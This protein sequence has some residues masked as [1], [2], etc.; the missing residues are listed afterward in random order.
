MAGLFDTLG[1]ATSGLRTVQSGI[2]TTGHNIANADTPGYTRQRSVVEASLPQMT[3]AGAIGTGVEQI[4][5]ERILDRFVGERLVRETSRQA[6]LDTQAAIYRQLESVVTSQEGEGLAGDLTSFFDALDDLSNAISPGQEAERTQLL[7]AGQSLVDSIHRY[8]TQLRDLQRGADR[9]ISG[10][11][12]E[13]NA[14]SAEIASLNQKIAAAEVTSPA[15]DLR[16]QREQLVL[17]LAEKVDIALVTDNQGMLSVR[18]SGGLPLVDKDIAA[19]LDAVVDPANPN[20]FDPSFS[21]VFYTGAG[22]SFDAT[23]L[24]RGGELGGLIEAR[25]TIIGGAIR[26]L[27]AFAYTVAESFNAVHR[28][29][30][31]IV[32]G[33]A[34]D[35]FAD[36]S[37]QASVDDAARNFALSADVD[38]AQGGSL[39]NIAAG[40]VANPVTGGPE[41]ALGDTAWVEQLKD[42]RTGNVANYLAGDVPGTPTGT[43]TTM[44]NALG[45]FIGDIGQGARS[46]ERSLAQQDSVLAAVRNR[47]DEISGVSIDEE[48]A[49]LVKLQASF[50]ANAKVLSTISTMLDDLFAAL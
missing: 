48:V 19:R 30:L 40:A 32:D 37:G 8:D 34:H 15:N 12:A 7:A 35:F 28:G 39:G 44:V 23:S 26:E 5:V 31:G 3:G 14:I 13:V 47:R 45:R 24:L 11:L 50:Q 2:A 1:T 36:L 27:D 16:D 29:G 20:P 18:I 25:D 38:P 49:E 4:S 22:T 9:G 43:S 41:A 46:A 33:A 10:L 42:L 17:A 6:T 21:Q